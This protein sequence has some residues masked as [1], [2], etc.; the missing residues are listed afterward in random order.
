MHDIVALEHE[1]DRFENDKKGTC[2]NSL[3]LNTQ[4]VNCELRTEI[5]KVVVRDM[6]ARLN[7]IEK[8][9]SALK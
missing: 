8:E 1:I 3:P 7:K 6:K 4:Y 2:S 5:N 9:F